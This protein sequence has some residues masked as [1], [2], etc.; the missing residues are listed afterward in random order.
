[1]RSVHCHFKYSSYFIIQ[2]WGWH[3]PNFLPLYFLIE[4]YLLYRILWFSVIHQQESA[5]GTPM[6]PPSPPHP[7]RLLGS[8]FEFPESHSKFPLAIYFTYGIVNF[9]VTLSIHLILSL[10]LSYHVLR[11]VFYVY[12]SIAAL[13]I[14][15]SV[16]SLQIPYT[17]PSIWY[18]FFSF[19]L[20]SLCITVGSRFVHLIRT[21]SNVFLFMAE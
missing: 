15:S 20:T 21:D 8:L 18:L 1:M 11:S 2:R 10:F 3:S 9:H 19:W 4:G 13:K 14:N 12:F 5:I 6:S 17:C 7:S 16:P